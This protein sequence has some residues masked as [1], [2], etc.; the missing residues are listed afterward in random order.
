MDNPPIYLVM[1]EGLGGV[2]H[3]SVTICRTQEEAMKH[4]GKLGCKDFRVYVFNNGT[5][6]RTANRSVLYAIK[7]AQQVPARYFRF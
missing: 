3:K 2:I 4:V 1:A 5:I 6:Y 7:L